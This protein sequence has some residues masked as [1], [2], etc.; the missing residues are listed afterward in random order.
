[1]VCTVRLAGHGRQ[2]GK[3][4]FEAELSRR[5][6]VQTNS[7]PGHP[8][9]C[10]K[11]GVATTALGTRVVHGS[12]ATRTNWRWAPTARRRLTVKDPQSSPS[13]RDALGSLPPATAA[14]APWT[15]YLS[16]VKDSRATTVA[17]T[18]P[19][20]SPSSISTP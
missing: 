11:A 2:G 19:T 6:I 16:S 7:R 10:G 13:T 15:S 8:T 18:S 20:S 17:S 12:A 14:A 1:M 5:H 4:S 3:N 9:T